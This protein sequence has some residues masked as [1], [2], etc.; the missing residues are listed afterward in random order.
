LR[1]VKYFFIPSSFAFQ[2]KLEQ[3]SKT[4]PSKKV[5]SFPYPPK[6]WLIFL[7]VL[8]EIR[9]R[10]KRRES[11]RQTPAIESRPGIAAAPRRAALPFLPPG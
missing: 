8:L 10:G 3:Q 9:E 1:V 11:A 7:L 4:C 6:N 5:S 2:K